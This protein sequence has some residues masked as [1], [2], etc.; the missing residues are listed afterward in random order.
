MLG[1]KSPERRA[2]YKKFIRTNCFKLTSE[3]QLMGWVDLLWNQPFRE[4]QY[5]AMD[6]LQSSRKLLTS[7]GAEMVERLVTEK[8][9]WDTV[10]ILAAN[11]LGDFYN[12]RHDALES[13]IVKTW[14][15]SRNVWLNRA[16]IL[17]QLKFKKDTRLDLLDAAIK[18]H[19]ASKDFFHQKAIGWAL[20]ELSKSNPIWVKHYT[21]EHNLMALSKRE[22]LRYLSRNE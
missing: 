6:E 9:W 1:I 13:K 2:I 7:R 21:A 4:Y 16:G 3:E 22:A 15:K 11:I 10:D 20:R 19:M 17:V 8:S 12:S 14:T 5:I 18:P